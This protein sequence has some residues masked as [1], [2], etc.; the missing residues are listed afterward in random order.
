MSSTIALWNAKQLFWITVSAGM[1][2]WEDNIHNVL[3]TL[4]GFVKGK[5]SIS[6][7]K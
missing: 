1:S 3:E 5:S 2:A 7:F 4:D 6:D